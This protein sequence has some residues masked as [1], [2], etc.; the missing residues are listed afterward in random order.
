[1]LMDVIMESL[2][3]MDDATLE[4]AI[5]GMSDEELE[6][7]NGY[8]DD[9]R[10]QEDDDA[11]TEQA[12]FE[13]GKSLV[14]ELMAL[15][16]DS[17]MDVIESTDTSVFENMEAICEKAINFD[18]TVYNTRN[19]PA[20]FVLTPTTLMEA[21]IAE[22]R[23]DKM[24]DI[25]VDYMAKHKYIVYGRKELPEGIASHFKE[26]RKITASNLT[27]FGWRYFKKAKAMLLKSSKSG[28]VSVEKIKSIADAANSK[29]LSGA[30]I[31]IVGKTMLE[32]V[33]YIMASVGLGI[34]YTAI[35]MPLAGDAAGHFGRIATGVTSV[36]G[37][38]QV[39]RD[40]SESKKSLN[41]VS[42]RA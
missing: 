20:K 25:L 8:L 11:A 6:I 35:S 22:D 7:V 5:D 42:S 18:Q 3:S 16:E 4:S 39:A 27:E 12:E 32:L 21:G 38:I 34:L 36:A 26:T 31:E 1:M 23:A 24:F 17:L 41:K 14:D 19:N 37:G 15:D 2:I 13:Y 28:E 30:G 29:A 40:Y 9:L 33:G 10:D